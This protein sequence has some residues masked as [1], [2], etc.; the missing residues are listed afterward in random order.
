MDL[1]TLIVPSFTS[2][3]EST[4][5]FSREDDLWRPGLAEVV[6]REPSGSPSFGL[7][8]VPFVPATPFV[9]LPRL[10]RGRPALSPPPPTR[11]GVAVV[12][13]VGGLRGAGT[14]PPGTRP[15]RRHL[16]PRC[17]CGKTGASDALDFLQPSFSLCSLSEPVGVLVACLPSRVLRDDLGLSSSGSPASTPFLSERELPKRTC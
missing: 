4:Y 9:R 15:S 7:R 1:K 8:S 6:L 2:L 17:R 11:L 5:P 14:H 16:S 10:G 3:C 12:L 13:V